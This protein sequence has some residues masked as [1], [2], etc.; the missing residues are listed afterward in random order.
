MAAGEVETPKEEPSPHG[1]GQGEGGCHTSR[2]VEDERGAGRLRNGARRRALTRQ[3][4][5]SGGRGQMRVSGRRLLK[6]AGWALAVLVVL[7][8]VVA[9]A[10]WFGGA[11]AVVWL[12]EH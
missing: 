3:N 8:G 7:T 11:R 5:I 10:V 6:I 4:V 9:A 12:V 2:A 1:R